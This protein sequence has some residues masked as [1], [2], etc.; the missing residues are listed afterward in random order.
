MLTFLTLKLV[1]RIVTIFTKCSVLDLIRCD[2]VRV[3]VQ[4]TVQEYSRLGN[5]VGRNML[6]CA[7]VQAS[8][9]L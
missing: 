6:H 5:S 7:C 4:L 2:A 9:E 8:A 3:M 1:V